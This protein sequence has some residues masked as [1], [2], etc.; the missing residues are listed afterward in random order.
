MSSLSVTFKITDKVIFKVSVLGICIYDIN[1]NKNKKQNVEKKITTSKKGFS[2]ILKDY[3]KNKN[4]KELIFE[5]FSL[6]KELCVEF[7]AI[8][9]HIR[10]KKLEVNLKIA[11]EGLA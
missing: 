5:L 2:D 8:L 11:E 1:S 9:K 10:I 6:I 7:S 3:A 4:N